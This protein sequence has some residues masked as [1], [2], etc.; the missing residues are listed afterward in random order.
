MRSLID[1]AQAAFKAGRTTTEVLTDGAFMPARAWPRF[2][3]LIRENAPVGA[4]TLVPASE[5]GELLHV[6]GTV[7]DPQGRP[8]KGATLYVYHTSAKGW[9]SDKAAHIG[10][11]AGDVKHARLFAYLNRPTRR[12]GTSSGP[13]VRRA[14]RPPTYPP[15]STCR[16]IRPATGPSRMPP[17][18]ASMTI[19]A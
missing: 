12:G 6:L 3:E 4:V 17:R 14:I 9:Y 18:F 16:S 19:R 5:P 10:G 15:T 2:R 11:V 8:V 13:S 7:R 1:Q